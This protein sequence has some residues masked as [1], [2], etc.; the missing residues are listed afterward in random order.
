[1]QTNIAFIRA[2]SW[3][4]TLHGS[5]ADSG[6]SFGRGT[7]ILPVIEFSQL[8]RLCHGNGRRK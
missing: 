6:C 7:G 2:L 1:L 3:S 8:G 4:Q 5:V